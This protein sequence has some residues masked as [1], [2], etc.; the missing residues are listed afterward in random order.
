MD[1][2]SAF[3]KKAMED[4]FIVTNLNKLK[5]DIWWDLSFKE[6]ISI[7]ENL[8]EGFSNFYPELGKPKFNFIILNDT[9]K[10]EENE[11][12]TFINA[13]LI[14][15]DNYYEILLTCLHELRHFYQRKASKLYEEKGIVHEL[16]DSKEEIERI[17]ENN[18][19]SSLFLHS[20]YIEVNT[21]NN[22]EYKIQ[23]VEWDAEMF[24]CMF[25][26]KFSSGFLTDRYDIKNCKFAMTESFKIFKIMANKENNII[27]FDNI[28]MLNYLDNVND[29]KP[30]FK[31]E[32]IKA[33][34]VM[35]ILKKKDYLTDNQIL[36]LLNCCFLEKMDIETKVDLF[37]RYLEYNDCDLKIDFLDDGYY[38]DGF[39][40]DMEEYN[41][42]KFI[43][44]LFLAV[45]DSKIRKI[46]EK[47]LDKL[48]FGFEKEIKINLMDEKNIIK[49]ENNPLYYRL[50]PYILF[51]NG[52]V[53]DEYFKLIRAIDT[54][55]EVY[56]NFFLDFSSF[57]KKYDNVPIIKK[58]EIL[59]GKKF[60]EIYKE[61]INV[62]KENIEKQGKT[63]K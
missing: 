31:K 53:K 20:N 21:L 62:M 26:T 56:D 14:E 61:M 49:E 47:E 40:L 4:K 39:L 43:E 38:F 18:T 59:T 25:L 41:V 30:Y 10:G 15:D 45:A 5:G 16:F 12:G 29:N 17:I 28:Y 50:Q 44:P 54:C 48:K 57:I 8:M 1:K 9:A 52:I 3:Y 63:I 2:F 7:F 51:R 60:D 27:D 24:A 33:D 19:R 6:R 36:K 37:N 46:T 42:F 35:S 32:K 34:E 11:E 23:P 58:A 55:Y 22:M 13:K